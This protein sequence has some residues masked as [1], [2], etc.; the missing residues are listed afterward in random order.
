VTPLEIILVF[1][2]AGAGAYLGS[3]LREKG[4]NLATREDVDRLVRATEEIKAEIAGGLW[5]E[6]NQWSFRAETYKQ[7]LESLG[8]LLSALKQMMYSAEWR[9]KIQDRPKALAFLN[10]LDAEYIQKA[11]VAF[12]RLIRAWSVATVWLP[13]PATR[14]L[15]DLRIA[16]A[17][18]QSGGPLSSEFSI[19]VHDAIRAAMTALMLAAR[20]DLGIAPADAKAS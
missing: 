5:L 20:N 15:E 8:D 2:L 1:V 17:T 3:Y 10:D 7:L 16:W 19:K 4:K 6:Q 11:G 12:E 9:P 14:A 13:V 18:A